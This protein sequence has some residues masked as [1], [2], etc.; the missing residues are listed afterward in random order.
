MD[1]SNES[2]GLW[3]WL[4][5]FCLVVLAIGG[6][7]TCKTALKNRNSQNHQYNA[8][9]AEK[10]SLEY[11]IKDN[12]KALGNIAADP[13]KKGL[14]DQGK[15]IASVNN[16]LN[17]Y[18]HAY[19]DFSNV[20]QFN[21]RG[22]IASQ[23][24][25]PDVMKGNFKKAGKGTAGTLES[26]QMHSYVIGKADIFVN[27]ADDNEIKG[28]AIVQH[29]VQNQGHGAASAYTYYEFTVD[30]HQNKI[31]SLSKGATLNNPDAMNEQMGN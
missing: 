13:A 31:T 17:Q 2:T 26:L 16:I 22:S 30:R 19:Y 10:H 28:T 3:R 1:S 8:A 18:F 24:A 27:S 5:V 4:G 15:Q 20:R 23:V 29:A 25:T 9:L 11:Q 12:R 7:L 21:N 14:Q 6:A